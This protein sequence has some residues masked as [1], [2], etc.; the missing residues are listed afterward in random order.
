MRIPEGAESTYAWC[1]LWFAVELAILAA[2]SQVKTSSELRERVHAR[3]Y[4]RLLNLNKYL[5]QLRA[6]W[7]FE[8]LVPDLDKLLRLK[9][10]VDAAAFVH[11]LM[12][13]R[14]SATS[15]ARYCA[16]VLL[17]GPALVALLYYIGHDSGPLQIPAACFFAAGNGMAL[18]F[19]A[20][21]AH[22]ETRINVGEDIV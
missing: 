11:T 13:R 3:T 6:N 17:L 22:L 2:L 7:P 4:Q 14:E 12:H 9:G 15:A 16:C 21:A 5:G 19:L 10:E 20:V 18:A 1:L 8:D